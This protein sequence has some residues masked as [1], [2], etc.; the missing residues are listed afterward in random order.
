MTP[1]ARRDFADTPQGRPGPAAAA[2]RGRRPSAR[3]VR[4]VRLAAVLRPEEVAGLR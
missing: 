4:S 2:G 1:R 3:C